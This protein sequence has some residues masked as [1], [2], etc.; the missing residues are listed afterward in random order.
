MILVLEGGR[1]EVDQP[2][3]GVEQ[4]LSLR[5]LAA[6]R[7]RRRRNLA[8]VGK[9]LVVIATEEDVLRLEVSVDQ[10]QIVED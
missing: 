3:L 5:C 1:S 2:N 6:D 10:V 7:R 4:D 8:V 9:G